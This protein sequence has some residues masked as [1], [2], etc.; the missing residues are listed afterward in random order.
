MIQ[1][2]TL[3]DD[4]PVDFMDNWV[5]RVIPRLVIQHCVSSLMGFECV[6][7]VSISR[8]AD[9]AVTP[10]MPRARRLFWP[11]QDKAGLFDPRVQDA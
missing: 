5:C 1:M 3:D 10:D 2:P 8:L 4:L 9:R 7:L 11:C 6:L